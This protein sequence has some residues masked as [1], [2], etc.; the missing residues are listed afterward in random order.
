MFELEQRSHRIAARKSFGGG[1]ERR[2]EEGRKSNP[3][4]QFMFNPGLA[5]MS[6]VNRV[7]HLLFNT[8]KVN[9]SPRV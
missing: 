2:R 6:W 1:E 5:I 4:G 9:S 7:V 3:T 8:I